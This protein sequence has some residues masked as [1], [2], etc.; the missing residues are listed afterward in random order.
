MVGFSPYEWGKLAVFYASYLY[1]PAALFFLWLAIARAG[2][3]RLGAV[4]TLMLLSV[5]G[6]ARFVEPKLL[7]TNEHEIR[8]DRCFEKGGSARVAVFA[9]LHEGLFRNTVSVERVVHAV[10]ATSPDFVLA[11]GDFVYFLH[12]DKFT[13]AFQPLADIQAPLFAVL[14]NHDWGKPSGPDVSVELGEVFPA[15][16][17]EIIDDAVRRLEGEHYA[18]ELVGLSDA[19]QETQDLSLVAEQSS[20]PRLVLTHHP[21]IAPSMRT[22]STVDLVVAGH[23]HGGQVKVPF[24]TC[25]LTHICGDHL[26]GL[27]RSGNIP[28]FTTSGTSMV[29]LPLRFMVPP[30]IDVLNIRYEACDEGA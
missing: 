16:D 9:D 1:F 21:I 20:D 28:I 7:F 10:N 4:A 27:S 13:K 25:W 8:F 18:I 3:L 6:Y 15:L 26:Y 5:F 2:A 11:A 24:L 17:I 12:P 30:R 19:W 14:G 22:K 29:M 23:T